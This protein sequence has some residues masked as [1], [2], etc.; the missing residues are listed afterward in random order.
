MDL[1]QKRL[2]DVSTR[3]ERLT[4]R[5]RELHK[6]EDDVD[7]LIE[8]QKKQLEAI[9]SMTRD[10]ARVQLMQSLDAELI[11]EKGT[12]IRRHAEETK[13]KCEREAQ[14]V[15]IQ[16]MQRYAGECAYDRTTT[17]IPLPSDEMKGRIIGR[18]GRNI[19]AIEQATGV[20]IIIDDTPEA[21]ILSC[22]NPI[23]R[24]I[25]KLYTNLRTAK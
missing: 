16:A 14:R 7:E 23:K 9:A 3:D 10:Q 5:E 8:K 12:L 13:A 20:D 15:I 25:A 21:V 2:D 17:T 18:E 11:N 1:I 4:Q 22:F 6:K 24:E 19:R